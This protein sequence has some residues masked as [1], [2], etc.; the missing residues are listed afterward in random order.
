MLLQVALRATDKVEDIASLLIDFTPNYTLS[1]DKAKN[2][3]AGDRKVFDDT[4]RAIKRCLND[5]PAVKR[6]VNK[7]TDKHHSTHGE[8]TSEAAFA[9]DFA[10]LVP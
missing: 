5:R 1:K 2:G 8:A 10:L 4:R 6:L 3:D 7:H 9:R